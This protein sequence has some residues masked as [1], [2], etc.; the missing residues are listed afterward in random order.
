MDWL[1]DIF[2]SVTVAY[3][4][5]N[6]PGILMMLGGAAIAGLLAWKSWERKTTWKW[7]PRQV[8]DLGLGLIVLYLL[9]MGTWLLAFWEP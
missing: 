8:F 1:S 2:M 3:L 7:S 9:G 5:R 4:I 6:F